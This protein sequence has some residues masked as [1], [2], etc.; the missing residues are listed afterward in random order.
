MTAAPFTVAR[1]VAFFPSM[2][3]GK[4]HAA[5]KVAGTAVCGTNVEL[6]LA[7]APWVSIAQGDDSARVHPMVCRRCLNLTARPGV[8]GQGVRQ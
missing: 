7:S 4:I 8:S 3:G 1:Q 6:D 5:W 2:T